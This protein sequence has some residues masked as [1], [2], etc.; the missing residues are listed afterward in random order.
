MGLPSHLRAVSAACLNEARCLFYCLVTIGIES[1]EV[2][3]RISHRPLLIQYLVLPCRVHGI[4]TSLPCVSVSPRRTGKIEVLG[5]RVDFFFFWAITSSKHFSNCAGIPVWFLFY[6]AGTFIGCWPFALLHPISRLTLSRGGFCPS[7]S[8]S[9]LTAQLVSAGRS[10]NQA[11]VLLPVLFSAVVF[12]G[13][14]GFLLKARPASNVLVLSNSC[15]W[16]VSPN[17]TRLLKTWSLVPGN[18][19]F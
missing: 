15:A 7:P 19:G 5:L 10:A 3:V 17:Q 12:I 14:L 4:V 1:V 16:F 8:A 6:E 9:I 2:H 18:L 11:S 13:V